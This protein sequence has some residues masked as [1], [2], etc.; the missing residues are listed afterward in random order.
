M[1]TAFHQP[2]RPTAKP[3]RASILSG[4]SDAGT[5]LTVPD[6]LADE[7]RNEDDNQPRKVGGNQANAAISLYVG[8]T[9]AEMIA[10]LKSESTC[11]LVALPT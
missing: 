7:K 6:C 3:E 10:R 5:Q 2:S 1:T 8:I 11:F 4:K 9:H